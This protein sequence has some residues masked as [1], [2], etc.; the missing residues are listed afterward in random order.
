MSIAAP[1]PKRSLSMKLKKKGKGR[2][3]R[4][5]GAG[6]G[7]KAAATRKV[8][9]IPALVEEKEGKLHKI[10]NLMYIPPSNIHTHAKPL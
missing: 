7:R 1:P 9:P 2:G 6:R 5:G 10:E 8:T 4:K 3:G